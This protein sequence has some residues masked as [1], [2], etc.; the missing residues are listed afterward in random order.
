[1]GGVASAGILQTRTGR[2]RPGQTGPGQTGPG[3][4]R[5]GWAIASWAVTHAKI[6]GIRQVSYAGY[7]WHAASGNRGWRRDA[8]APTERVELG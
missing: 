7:V 8:T 2:T 6:Y 4:T 5:P 1:V 3:Q